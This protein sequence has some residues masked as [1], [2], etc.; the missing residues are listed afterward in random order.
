MN[1]FPAFD[2]YNWL[3]NCSVTLYSKFKPYCMKRVFILLCLI[4]HIQEVCSAQTSQGSIVL[5]GSIFLNSTK[6]ESIDYRT[7]EFGF[8]PQVGYL[9]KDNFEIGGK[10]SISTSKY[11]SGSQES[12]SFGWSIGPYARYYHFTENNRFAFYGHAQAVIGFG[13]NSYEDAF[14]NNEAKSN[15]FSISLSPGFTYFFT[16]K[17]GLDLQLSGISLSWRDPNTDADNNMQTNFGASFNLHPSLGLR[18]Y[19]K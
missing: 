1:L 10:L 2:L 18:Y 19:I 13:K 14:N 7:N 9:I 11:E 16:D 15:S 3:K 4:I 6:Q 17:W 12:K 5:G 8:S